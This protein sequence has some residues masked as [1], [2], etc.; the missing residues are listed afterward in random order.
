MIKLKKLL[1]NLNQQHQKYQE[2]TQ[3]SL[4]TFNIFSILR[5]PNDEVNLHSKFIF[6]LLNPQGSHQ[7]GDR[8]LKLFFQELEVDENSLEYQV[9]REKFNIDILI[10]TQ[11][12][13]IIIENKIET[14]DHS[15][16]LS[17][18]YRQIKEEGYRESEIIFFYLTLFEEEP[19][20]IKMRDKVKNITYKYEIHNWIEACIKKVIHLA[21]L[22]DTL[23]Q[24]LN[25]INQLTE[26]S[27]EKGFMIEVK[28]ILL[29][30]NN[31]A[32]I[33]SIEDAVIEA[34][35]EI[36]LSFW[37]ALKK[38]LDR[39]YSFEFYSLNGEKSIK[40]SVHKYYKK[41]KNRKDFGFEY[42]VDENLYFFIELRNHLYYG[43]DFRKKATIEQEE[44]IN[45]L[46]VDWEDNY[47][48]YSDKKL[49]FEV[50]NTPNVLALIDKEEQQKTIKQISDEVFSLIAQYHN[51]QKETS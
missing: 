37:N 14:Q 11:N 28:D 35:I 27:Q 47:W 17:R 42:Q 20:E 38:R 29:K 25:L 3:L 51:F 19:N 10:T 40:K 30:E 8:F 5:K 7:Q 18:Y 16:Q 46:W 6:E 36:Q 44:Q 24:Y 9:F 34:K 32:T 39:T 31:L 4:N 15:E 23:V 13:A 48:K 43:F 41:R 22:R 1:S 45:A 2:L 26:Q 49:N 33:L 50:F 21:I 12:R